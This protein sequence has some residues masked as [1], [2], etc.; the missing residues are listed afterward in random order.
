MLISMPLL[1]PS[2]SA[3][4]RRELLILQRHRL[5][6]KAAFL[7]L[8]DHCDKV[9]IWLN[10]IRLEIIIVILNSLFDQIFLSPSL[11]AK[12]LDLAGL[13]ISLIR[14]FTARFD[15]YSTLVSWTIFFVWLRDSLAPHDLVSWEVSWWLHADF[16]LM[17][18]WCLHSRPEHLWSADT[19]LGQQ[20]TDCLF[21]W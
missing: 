18:F 13:D 9:L 17:G 4:N 3:D 12:E 21:N 1:N 8:I 19:L 15:H 5:N 6:L 20:C 16:F 7:C 11:I 2:H 10:H 14:F